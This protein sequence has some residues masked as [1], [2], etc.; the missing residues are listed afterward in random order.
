MCRPRRGSLP[1]TQPM[2]SS[3]ASAG[4]PPLYRGSP[5]S[6]SLPESSQPHFHGG[7]PQ[8]T[9]GMLSASVTSPVSLSPE[10]YMNHCGLLFRVLG[11]SVGDE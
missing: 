8:A 3:L 1:G 4:T 11:R 5:Y 6:R 9:L 2:P 7:S 10:A